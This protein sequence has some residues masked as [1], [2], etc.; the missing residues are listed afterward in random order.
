MRAWR[1]VSGLTG[2]T[3]LA[4]HRLNWLKMENV[5]ARVQA[6]HRYWAVKLRNCSFANRR[7]R[8]RLSNGAKRCCSRQIWRGRGSRWARR[9][10]DGCVE[11][12][13]RMSSVRSVGAVQNRDP[14]ADCCGKC[15]MELDAGN[16]TTYGPPV[17]FLWGSAAGTTWTGQP[18]VDSR[19]SRVDVFWVDWWMTT[20]IDSWNGLLLWGY[21]MLGAPQVTM[22]GRPFLTVYPNSVQAWCK[23]REQ[24][25]SLFPD[26]KW[27][28]GKEGGKSLLQAGQSA[29]VQQ[30]GCSGAESDG[31]A[32]KYG[33]TDVQRQ[34]EVG[35]KKEPKSGST[36][37]L[38]GAQSER[39]AMVCVPSRGPSWLF[40]W[41][42]AHWGG[43]QGPPLI[44]HGA[45]L[46]GKCM[47]AAV[48]WYSEVV[49]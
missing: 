25:K 9:A 21:L 14:T 31:G 8:V 45:L 34:V 26:E 15:Q 44:P 28:N 38:R 19:W 36:L 11:R 13:T 27:I 29:T 3:N 4:G 40:H 37:S 23:R 6:E 30:F 46:I 41:G 49:P 7:Y 42:G 43:N 5:R 33:G 2:T 47:G 1:L 18:M 22:S 48:R 39:S 24:K 32:R 16:W 17:P 20:T 12:R 10:I 35:S